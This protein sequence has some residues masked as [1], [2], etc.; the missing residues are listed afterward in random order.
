MDVPEQV[1]HVLRIHG[2]GLLRHAGGQIGIA[3]KKDAPLGQD[4]GG[5]RESLQ[6]MHNK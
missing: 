6:S 4:M 5:A 2:R 1:R 3:C